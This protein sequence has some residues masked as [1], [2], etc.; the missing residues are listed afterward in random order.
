[1]KRRAFQIEEY[2]FTA[3]PQKSDELFEA[4]KSK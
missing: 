1:M 2:S 3:L 4:E